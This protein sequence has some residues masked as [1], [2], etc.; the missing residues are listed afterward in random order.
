MAHGLASGPACA[1]W[2][3]LGRLETHQR[4]VTAE[5]GHGRSFTQL[6]HLVSLRKDRAGIA[7][8]LQL[9]PGAPGSFPFRTRPGFPFRAFG[10]AIRR[11]TAV[12]LSWTFDALLESEPTAQWKLERLSCGRT[13]FFLFFFNLFFG[14]SCSLTRV[15]AHAYLI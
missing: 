7:S 15:Y 13:C 2:L 5:S 1:A 6:S 14:W 10:A 8:S 4:A 12:G 11:P 9:S 3:G